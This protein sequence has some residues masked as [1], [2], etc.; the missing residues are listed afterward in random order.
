M[1]KFIVTVDGPAAS[2]KQKIAK[3]ISKKWNLSH[4]DSGILYR[5]IALIFSK[6]NINLDNYRQVNDCLSKI[7]AISYRNNKIIRTQEISNVASKIAINKAVRKKINFL[8]Y[9][10]VKNLNKKGFVIDGR[11]IGSKVFKDADLKLYIEVDVK[12]RAKRRYKQLIDSDEKSIYQKIL[13]DIKLRDKT[14]K[15]RKHSP[16]V[17][18][19]GA[20]IVDNNSSFKKTIKQITTIFNKYQ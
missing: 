13:K 16:L 8:Q 18:P 9:E 3:Y 2:G 12:I 4:L 1:K 7:N 11:D 20:H 10:Y 14:D 5:R 19:K 17:I 15:N 6:N